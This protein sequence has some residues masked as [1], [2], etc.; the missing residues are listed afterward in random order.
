MQEQ[1]L[2]ILDVLH[3][4]IVDMNDAEK[5]KIKTPPKKIRR[6]K[7]FCF[8]ALLFLAITIIGSI[9]ALQESNVANGEKKWFFAQFANFLKK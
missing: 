7:L 8:T 2:E 4:E 1:D 5:N 9:L 3:G 6:R